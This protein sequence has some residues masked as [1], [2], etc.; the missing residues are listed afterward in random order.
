MLALNIYVAISLLTIFS[1][2]ISGINKVN[3]TLVKI[4][5]KPKLFLIKK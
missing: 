4:K 3:A 5:N 1:V 2:L